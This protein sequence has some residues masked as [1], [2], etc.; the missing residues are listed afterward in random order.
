[1]YGC[2]SA[3]SFPPPRK[4]FSV[5]LDV[6]LQALVVMGWRRGYLGV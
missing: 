2:D 4:V 1:M 3:S 5:L 6:S